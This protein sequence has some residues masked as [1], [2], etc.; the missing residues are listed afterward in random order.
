MLEFWGAAIRRQFHAAID[1]LGNAIK[2]ARILCG[3]VGSAA[4][5]GTWRFM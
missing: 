5:F 1:M 3:S 2:L 4:L